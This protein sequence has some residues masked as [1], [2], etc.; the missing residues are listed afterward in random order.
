MLD[1]LFLIWFS[2]SFNLFSVTTDTLLDRRC[3]KWKS[4]EEVI[5]F[6]GAFLSGLLHQA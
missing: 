2:V 6:I 1:E 5:Y 3:L 4:L